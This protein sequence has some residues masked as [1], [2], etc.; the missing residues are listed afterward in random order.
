MSIVRNKFNFD[1][2]LALNI[3]THLKHSI[4]IS[5]TYI[6][7]YRHMYKFIPENIHFKWKKHVEDV[8]QENNQIV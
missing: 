8:C 7:T 1:Y 2:T 3:V 4:L 6:F 5:C